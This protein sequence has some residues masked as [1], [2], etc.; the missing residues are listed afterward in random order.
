MAV[1]PTAQKILTIAQQNVQTKGFNGFSYRDLAQEIGIKTSSIH[2]HFPTK[3]DLALALVTAYREAFDAELAQISLKGN[4]RLPDRY[5]SR[6]QLEKYVKL[7]ESN[8]AVDN[9]FCLCGML[10]S[11]INSLSPRVKQAIEGFFTN[12]ELWLTNLVTIG[13]ADGS[14]KSTNS[15]NLVAAQLLATLE[16]A[17]LIARSAETDNVGK[18][19]QVVKGMIESLN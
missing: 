6:S 15:P 9:R 10:A 5:A 18:F 19:R 16:G 12:N 1:N 17:M 11:E 4:A 8:L 3:D 7:F 13:Q 2:Y 14:F